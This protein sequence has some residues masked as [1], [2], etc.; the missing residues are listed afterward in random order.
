M[1]P[2]YPQWRHYPAWRTPGSWVNEIAAIVA[3]VQPAISSA[4]LHLESN[5]VLELLRTGLE[6]IGF[7]VEKKGGKLPRPVLFGD[8][9]TILKSFNV[10]AFRPT[11]GVALEVESGGAVYNNRVLLD[12]VKFSVGADV[13]CGAILVPVK[14]E[15]A[16]PWQDPYPE[17]VKLFDAILRIRS[18]SGCLWKACLIVGY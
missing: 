1:S 8:E 2:S 16:K 6:S 15:T 18:D 4:S 5:Q 12:M 11:D 14:Y 10:D 7:V 9:G 13:R 17:A 3:N